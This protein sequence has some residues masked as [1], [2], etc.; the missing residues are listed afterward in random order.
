MSATLLSEYGMVWYA[1]DAYVSN[2][3]RNVPTKNNAATS[4]ADLTR[5]YIAFAAA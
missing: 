4:E 2:G 5:L 1:S 3:K